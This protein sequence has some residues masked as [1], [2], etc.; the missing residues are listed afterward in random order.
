MIKLQ[1]FP[2]LLETS[3]TT[4]PLMSKHPKSISLHLPFLT[5]SSK[6]SLDTDV[7]EQATKSHTPKPPPRRWLYCICRKAPTHHSYIIGDPILPPNSPTGYTFEGWAGMITTNAAG[8]RVHLAN[9]QWH[10]AMLPPYEEISLNLYHGQEDTQAQTC[11]HP[12]LWKRFREHLIWWIR[13][14]YGS[15]N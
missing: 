6:W 4:T 2:S 5:P 13:Q 12:S 14:V 1:P 8:E 11:S 9:F 10:P 15:W 7:F 3:S